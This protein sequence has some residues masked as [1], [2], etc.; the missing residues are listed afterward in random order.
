MLCIC[1]TSCGN[2]KQKPAY[3]DA[4]N[5]TSDGSDSNNYITEDNNPQSGETV[6]VPFT[7]R[8]GVKLIEVKINQ[9][10]GVDM[11]L[12]SGCSTTLISIDEA[13]YLYNKGV[14]TEDDIEGFQNAQIADGSI[15]ANMVVNLRELA[16][17][18]KITCTDV[19]ATVSNNSQ[20]P[21]LLG[22]EVLNR[23]ASYEVD[24]TNKV[25]NFKLN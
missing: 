15:V 18:G 24:N 16:I 21:L 25:I 10:I 3:F 5:T 6:S 9:S 2:D 20:A 19:Q 11:I 17:G 8:N 4:E 22:N 7:E 23:T 14:L 1:S 12:D 13:N